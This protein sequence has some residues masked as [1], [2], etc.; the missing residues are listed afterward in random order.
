MVKIPGKPK[1]YNH[2]EQTVHQAK[3]FRKK[4]YFDKEV[5]TRKRKSQF[6][7]ASVLPSE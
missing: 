6:S 7:H 2:V 1:S 3:N 4:T 5:S